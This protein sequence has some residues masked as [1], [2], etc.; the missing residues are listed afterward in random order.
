MQGHK[1]IIERQ[2]KDGEAARLV[3]RLTRDKISDSPVVRVKYHNKDSDHFEINNNNNL[4]KKIQ[5][6]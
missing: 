1:V 4:A 3:A 6:L 5:R 2:G